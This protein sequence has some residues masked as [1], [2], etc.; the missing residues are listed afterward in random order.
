[1]NMATMGSESCCARTAHDIVPSFSS[2]WYY[3]SLLRK[4]KNPRVGLL[5]SCSFRV[6]ACQYMANNNNKDI[7]KQVGLFQNAVFF[8]CVRACTFGFCLLFSLVYVWNE[9]ILVVQFGV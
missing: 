6:K 2:K 8:F 7:Y 1:M 9:M 3:S 5:F 4:N